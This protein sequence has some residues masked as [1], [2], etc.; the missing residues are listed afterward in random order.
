MRGNNHGAVSRAGFFNWLAA[1]FAVFAVAAIGTPALADVGLPPPSAVI[2]N[3]PT[4][5]TLDVRPTGSI[6]GTY[7]YSYSNY[8]QITQASN[9][10]HYQSVSA[11]LNGTSEGKTAHKTLTSNL[12]DNFGAT[13]QGKFKTTTT[14]PSSNT[15]AN[16]GGALIAGQ[17]M[18]SGV[19]RAQ[20][21]GIAEAIANGNY[22]EAARVASASVADA[23]Y[24]GAFNGINNIIND[25]QTKKAQQA[26]AQAQAAAE[27][28]AAANSFLKPD[29]NIYVAAVKK[30]TIANAPFLYIP[31][32]GQFTV[33]PSSGFAKSDVNSPGENYDFVFKLYQNGQ[34]IGTYNLKNDKPIGQYGWSATYYSVDKV[35]VTAQNI[36][37]IKSN[38]YG[39]PQ[40]APSDFFATESE[41]AAALLE[42]MNRNTQALTDVV[43][44]I[45]AAGGLNQTNT[46]TTVDNGGTAQTTFLTAPYTPVGSNQ[47]QQTQFVVNKDGSVTATTIARPDLAAHT[48][49]APTRAPVGQ[50]VTAP[51]TVAPKET[52]T[53]EAPDICAN[54]PNSLM[55]AEVG[56]ADYED[57]VVP[58]KSIDVNFSP[59]DIFS[60]DGVCPQPEQFTVMGTTKE[61]S[62]EPACDGA[63]K[64]RPIAIASVI[65]MCSLFAFA[66][67]KEI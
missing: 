22:G 47:A 2:A 67:V 26:V 40:P 60:T 10:R 50:T 29:G 15:L 31:V 6:G 14:L 3:A 54:N 17:V 28:A 37:E 44:A 35:Q 21:G 33:N 61:I 57:P 8:D 43:N 1:Y 58:E 65:V 27:Q 45:A 52:A 30:D 64:I 51:S 34:V 48:S 5:S 49:Q 46:T 19:Q 55:C 53:P 9:Q 63:R 38:L 62:F 11:S 56:S 20:A 13:A 4:G 41:I 42:A 32:Q 59:A 18:G 7:T 25:V 23:V 39:M 36:D 66:A 16:L 24:A 12:R